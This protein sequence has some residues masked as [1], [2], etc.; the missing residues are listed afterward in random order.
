MPRK[1][2]SGLLTLL[3]HSIS[4][5]ASPLWA[6]AVWRGLALC[7]PGAPAVNKSQGDPGL[8]TGTPLGSRDGFVRRAAQPKATVMASMLPTRAAM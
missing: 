6:A 2:D 1:D 8:C 5:N 7:W 4:R 3:W